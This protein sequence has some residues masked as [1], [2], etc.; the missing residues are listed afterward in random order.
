MENPNNNSISTE[1]TSN[2]KS[3]SYSTVL[4][5]SFKFPV[6]DQAIVFPSVEGISKNEYIVAVGNII[7]PCNVIFASRIS[8]GRICVYFSNKELVES[9]MSDHKGIYFNNEFIAARRL[10]SP[11]KRIILSNVSPHIPNEVILQE[12]EKCNLKVVSRISF[13]GAGIGDPQYKHVFSFRR[14]V[15]IAQDENELP[16]SIVVNFED[17]YFR[18]FL[19]TD[20]LRCFVCKELGHVAGKCPLSNLSVLPST[21]NNVA[22]SPISKANEVSG[23]GVGVVLPM[24]DDTSPSTS[25]QKRPHSPSTISSENDGKKSVN[26]GLSKPIFKKPK[27]RKLRKTNIPILKDDTDI[28]T[29]FFSVFNDDS[30]LTFDQFCE[31]LNE[32]KGQTQEKVIEIVLNMTTDP[33]ALIALAIKAVKQTNTNSLKNRLK[34]IVNNLKCRFSYPDETDF[35]DLSQS[36]MG[37]SEEISA[38]ELSSIFS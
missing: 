34:R 16:N 1:S 10:I 26:L 6:R 7:Q 23:G 11:A 35:S 27:Q 29:E 30:G 3:K 32:A 2:P 13:I 21:P 18:I 20:E 14:Q 33:H 24:E 17:E 25:T 15:Y 8:N 9:F 22:P 4:S 5:T 12:I 37:M 28:Y 31:F 36:D 19:T 38:E